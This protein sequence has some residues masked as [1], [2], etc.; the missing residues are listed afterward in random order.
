V[1]DRSPPV[2]S[3]EAAPSPAFAPPP[4]NPR[5]PLFDG[6]RGLA[7][8]GIL[9]FHVAEFTNQL[10]FGA[11]GRFDE[12]AGSEA[13]IT[14][15]VISGFLLY[16]P[17]AA[18]H[19]RGSGGPSARRYARRRALRILPAY[20]TVLTVLAIYPGIAGVLTGNGWRYYGYLQ[21]YSERTLGRGIPVAWTL[22]VE[23]TFY[24]VM[25]IWAAVI[26]RLSPSGRWLRQ[27]LGGLAL[28][29]AL[30]ALIQLAAAHQ[31][32]NHLVEVSLLGQCI[33]LGMGMAFAVIS[34]V[35][36]LGDGNL[37]RVT[38]LL[39]AHPSL[40]WLG[41]AAAYVGLMAI[42]PRGGL[43]GLIAA[44]ATRQSVTTTA[45][46]IVLEAIVV[47]LLVTPAVFGETRHG[48]PGRL[49]ALRPIVWL[50]VISYSFYLWHLTLVELIATRGGAGSFSARGF[51]LLAHVHS[52]RTF[53][54]FVVALAVTLVIA[55]LSYR[56]VELPFLRRK[57]RRTAAPYSPAR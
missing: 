39:G 25:P 27:E 18:A 34:V 36:Q 23:V 33:W 26:R 19:V 24:I 45:L 48:A 42:V 57:E 20:W 28:W 10:G 38:D 14:F 54:L 6:L 46:K 52:A 29:A 43:F 3:A 4:G 37:R 49:L 17:Y 30:G 22:C 31:L 53:V 2:G 32:V 51:N 7:V 44:V 50:G 12:V 16:R 11:A 41:A 21:L 13:V 56:F 5:F 40:C 8:L 47:I 55:S 15:F 9:A 35:A 1:I